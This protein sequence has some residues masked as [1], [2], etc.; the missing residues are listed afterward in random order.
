MSGFGYR[1]VYYTIYSLSYILICNN[2]CFSKILLFS[3]LI[4]SVD[5]TFIRIFSFPYPCSAFGLQ[6]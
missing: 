1:F 3:N 4:K 6:L 2:F 5:R